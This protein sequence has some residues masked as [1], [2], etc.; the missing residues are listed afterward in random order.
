MFSWGKE[1][2]VDLECSKLDS[3]NNVPNINAIK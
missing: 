1:R 3:F 2:Q